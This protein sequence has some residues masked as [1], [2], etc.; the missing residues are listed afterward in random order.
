[1]AKRLLSDQVKVVKENCVQTRRQWVSH[2]LG[3]SFSVVI[4]APIGV[5]KGQAGPIT[6]IKVGAE[7]RKR[8]ERCHE[9]ACPGTS[10]HWRTVPLWLLFN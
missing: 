1:M 6:D 2:A 4:T 9:V 10:R 8:I 3:P 5:E 7:K